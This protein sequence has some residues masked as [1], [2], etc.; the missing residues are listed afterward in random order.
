MFTRNAVVATLMVVAMAMLAAACGGAGAE[1]AAEPPTTVDGADDRSSTGFLGLST[2][3]AAARADEQ[4]RPWRVI[5]ED[6]VDLAVTADYSGDRLNFTVENGVVVAAATD[7][8]MVVDGS[9]RSSCQGAV[10]VIGEGEVIGVFDV[11]GDDRAEVFALI[12]DDTDFAQI[13]LWTWDE[14]CTLH[15]VTLDGSPA[16]LAA[17]LTE[18]RAAGVSVQ[19]HYADD[20]YTIELTSG[21]GGT[22]YEGRITAY[23]LEGS[24]LIETSGEGAAYSGDDAVGIAVL[25]LGDVT[26]P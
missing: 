16:V 3:E 1:M 10:P 5:R 2:E 13:G 20:L 21:D 8:E 6:G 14:D 7:A 23:H 17:G 9:T 22:T 18:S 12:D 26:Y 4:G 19:S 15:R 25:A 11:N 24:Q